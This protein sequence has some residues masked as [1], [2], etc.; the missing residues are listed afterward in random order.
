MRVETKDKVVSLIERHIEDIKAF[1]V[2]RLGLFGS[3]ARG[4]SNE[5]SDVDILVEFDPESKTFDNF[6]HL[7]FYLEDL[8]DRRVELMTTDALSPYIGPHILREVE[9]VDLS[10]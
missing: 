8:L 5:A 6:I 1:G 7:A 4:E 10:T 3:F 9:Y 2:T